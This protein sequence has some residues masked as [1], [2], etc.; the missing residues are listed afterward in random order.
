M[1]EHLRANLALRP[2]GALPD[3]IQH[4]PDIGQPGLLPGRQI[5]EEQLACGPVGSAEV[6]PQNLRERGEVGLPDD[7]DLFEEMLAIQWRTTANGKIQLESKDDIR[8]R[9][10]RSTDRADA[11]SMVTRDCYV[12]ESRQ[13]RTSRYETGAGGLVT[14]PT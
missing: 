9:I 10:G 8:A 6:V 11:V 1:A 4:F 12:P 5:R 13:W 14:T 7:P 2:P 3:V